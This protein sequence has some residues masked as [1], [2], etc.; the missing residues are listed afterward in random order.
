MG[1]SNDGCPYIGEIPDRSGQYVCAGFSGHG[2]PQT[3]LAAEAI[4]SMVVGGK[5]FEDTEL[6]GLFKISPDRLESQEEH[7]SLAGW[8]TVMKRSGPKL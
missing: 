7:T 1:Y 8:K 4:A 2:M 5:S 3:F 6:P